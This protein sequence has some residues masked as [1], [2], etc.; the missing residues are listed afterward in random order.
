MCDAFTSI[1]LISAASKMVHQPVDLLGGI[2]FW[3]L[4]LSCCSATQ[5]RGQEKC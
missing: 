1:L 2:L 3:V 5:E 4:C